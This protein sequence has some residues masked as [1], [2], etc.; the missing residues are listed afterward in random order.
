MN[1]AAAFLSS[2]HP[3]PSI[4]DFGIETQGRI[5]CNQG[6]LAIRGGLYLLLLIDT[7][8]SHFAYFGA[9]MYRWIRAFLHDHA[10]WSR[11]LVAEIIFKI[12][13]DVIA[14]LAFKMAQ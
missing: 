7:I 3:Y 11:Q 9:P 4:S 8:L 12:M 1:Q 10:T 6:I 14:D 5:E 13:N 2:T